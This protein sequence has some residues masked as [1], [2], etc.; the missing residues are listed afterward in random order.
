MNKNGLLERPADVGTNSARS[1]AAAERELSR[2]FLRC[3]FHALTRRHV[4]DDLILL[5][6]L[7]DNYHHAA[8]EA[9]E[10]R[11][12]SARCEMQALDSI[13]TSADPEIGAVRRLSALPVW[14]LICW[15]DGHPKEAIEHLSSSLEACRDLSA[16]FEHDY[17]T[18]KRLHLA[19]NIARVLA[20][21]GEEHR[22]IELAS[23]LR[24]VAL[25]DR[26]AWPYW[27]RE[28]LQIPLKENELQIIEYQLA[29]IVNIAAEFAKR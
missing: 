21:C 10:G 8:I 18:A 19:A 28:S 11:V 9:K 26:D 3:Q 6:V 22:S 17:L 13:S 12:D 25:G 14:A 20:S 4:L 29:R 23:S 2:E 16:V 5:R 27:G 24:S 7:V 15:K 1:F